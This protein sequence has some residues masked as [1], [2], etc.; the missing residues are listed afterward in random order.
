MENRHEIIFNLPLTTDE[1]EKAWFKDTFEDKS[2][3]D[4]ALGTHDTPTVGTSKALKVTGTGTVGGSDV[5]SLV[6]LK[7]SDANVTLDVAHK[8]A[9][10][11]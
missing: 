1:K 3:W 4:S 10:T 7:R 11:F 6:K 9:G 8:Q 5:G 2:K